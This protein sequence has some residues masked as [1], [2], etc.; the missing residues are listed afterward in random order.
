MQEN[1]IIII[2]RDSARASE[3]KNQIVFMDETNVLVA[4]PDDWRECCDSELIRAVFVG[5]DMSEDEV[6]DL[7]GEIGAINQQ[8]PIVL[9]GDERQAA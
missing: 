7:V 1:V 8:A 3:L 2:D 6:R 4:Q 5:P 9:L